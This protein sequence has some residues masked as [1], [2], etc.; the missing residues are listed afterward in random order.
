MPWTN[1]PFGVSLTTTTGT[2]SGMLNATAITLTSSTNAASGTLTV[3]TVSGGA[4]IFSGTM[5]VTSSITGAT[6]SVYGG[7]VSFALS[8]SATLALTSALSISGGSIVAPFACYPEI[9]WVAGATGSVTVSIRVVGGVDSTGSALATLTIGSATTQAA[10]TYTTIG[11]T[12]INQG[13]AFV[14]TS[15]V[16]ATANSSIAAL[17]LIAASA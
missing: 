8:G 4:G 14:F 1:F 12:L 2:V 3:G 15:A 9:V 6:G 16:M 13:S 17:N 5:S 10:T 7:K 11:S